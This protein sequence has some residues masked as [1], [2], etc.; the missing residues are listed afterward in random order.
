LKLRNIIL[1][2]RVDSQGEG[3]RD[4]MREKEKREERHEQGCKDERWSAFGP[5]RRAINST[6][7]GDWMEG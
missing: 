3:R 4:Q 5:L 7:I 1:R 6:R 2:P